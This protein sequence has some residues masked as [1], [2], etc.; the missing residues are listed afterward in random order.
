MTTLLPTL[1]F[2][3]LGLLVGYWHFTSLR[4]IARRLTGPQPFG[5]GRML[6]LQLLRI[7]VLVVAGLLAVRQGGVPLLALSAGVLVARALLLARTRRE[8][9]KTT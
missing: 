7:A 9:D 6:M 3:L 8:E 1:L 2:A 5:W 4:W